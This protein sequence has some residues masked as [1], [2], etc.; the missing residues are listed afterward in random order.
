MV[1]QK[2]TFKS[3]NKNVRK[4]LQILKGVAKKAIRGV[5]YH[6]YYFCPIAHGW[7]VNASKKWSDLHTHHQ[8]ILEKYGWTGKRYDAFLR[9]YDSFSFCTEREQF[10][11]EYLTAALPQKH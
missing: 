11:H 10:L 8:A 1:Q 3:L 5:G 2:I 4:A 9:W 6:S 7:K